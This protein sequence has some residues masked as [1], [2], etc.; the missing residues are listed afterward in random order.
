MKMLIANLM[1]LGVL[2]AT[3]AAT[4][5][6]QTPNE[7]TPAERARA[8]DAQE[9]QTQANDR[10]QDVRQHQ[11]QAADQRQMRRVDQRQDLRQ[12]RQD[13]RQRQVQNFDRRQFQR[14]VQATRR[15]RAGFYRAPPGFAYRRWTYGQRLPGIYFAQN[16]WLTNWF[17]SS[18]CSR[19]RKV[20]F[21]CAT[22]LT[23]C[24]SIVSAATSSR[25]VTGSLPAPPAPL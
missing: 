7:P 25:C 10:R 2:G 5:Q 23:P 14:N 12:D 19:R 1:A 9:R 8:H 3:T 22:D 21:G 17:T 24:S 15:F 11:V 16:Y 18:A 20:W 4:A 13:I 6:S